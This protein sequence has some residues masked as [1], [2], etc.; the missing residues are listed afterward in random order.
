MGAQPLLRYV[1][2]YEKSM[3]LVSNIV[4]QYDP[5]AYVLASFTS[6]WNKSHSSDGYSSKSMLD[7]I[8]AY[9]NAEG[10][11]R[12]GVAAHPYP[13]DFFK[14]KFWEADT[15]ATY[16]EDSGFSTFKNIEVI[17]NWMLRREHYYKGE[18][19]RILFFSENGVNSLDN[20]TYNL[21]VQAAGAAWAWKKTMQNAGV[22]AIM[23]HNWWDNPAEGLCLGLRTKDHVAKPS[24]YVWQAAGTDKESSVFDQYLSIIGISNW[25]QI[26]HGVST[27]GSEN[28]RLELDQSSKSDMT[29][30][31]DGTYQY[32][33]LKTTG[34]D[35]QVSTQAM[36][37]A[38]SDNSNTL[39]FEYQSAND[40]PDFQVFISPLAYEDRSVKV[41]LSASTD[42]KRVYINLAPLAKQYGWGGA[43]SKLRFDPGSVSGRTMKIRHICVNS[44]EKSLIANLST[45]SDGANQKRCQHRQ[46]DHRHRRRRRPVLL[47]VQ[48]RGQSVAQGHEDY[49]RISSINLRAGR[50]DILR[51]LRRRDTLHQPGQPECLHQ[52]DAE[53]RGHRRAVPNTRLGLR[54]RLYALRSRHEIRTDIQDTQHL[55]QHRRIRLH[56][57]PPAG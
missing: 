33:T 12:W 37:A 46:C 31:Y 36:S 34:G 38:K 27:S 55:H 35:P 49:V 29:I 17:S 1:D 3:R 2:T 16:S 40:I 39:V 4:R 8:V 21:K 13:Q 10:D 11:Y 22:D 47:L 23:W 43:G 9:S 28:T 57:Q 44:G 18:E 6:S 32:Y 30:T 53:D 42:W 54:R 7:N 26:H 5:N 19:K 15:Q 41:P 48:A 24:W 14:P 25:G 20:S 56:A 52:M 45:I 51:R 50:Q